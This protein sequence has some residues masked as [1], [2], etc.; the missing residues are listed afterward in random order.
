VGSCQFCDIIWHQWDGIFEIECG[1]SIR[2]LAVFNCVER[3]TF[4]GVDPVRMCTHNVHLPYTLNTPIRTY[5]IAR[6]A[7]RL[8]R[9]QVTPTRC[10]AACVWCVHAVVPSVIIP[11]C[12]ISI[13]YVFLPS[14]DLRTIQP[15]STVPTRFLM[16]PLSLFSPVPVGMMHQ[17]CKLQVSGYAWTMLISMLHDALIMHWNLLT[18]RPSTAASSSRNR[19]GHVYPRYSWQNQIKNPWDYMKR[20][21]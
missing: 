11:R 4:Q 8:Q 12:I 1:Y 15:Y 21:S 13:P 9:F 2:C 18:S 6:Y 16:F 17:S 7:A 20:Q 10:W 19:R 3:T 5:P 14:I